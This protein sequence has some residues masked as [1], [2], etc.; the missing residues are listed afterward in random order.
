MITLCWEM[1]WSNC[2]MEKW[3]LESVFLN[4][5][6]LTE[7]RNFLLL[8]SFH[9]KF[10]TKVRVGKIQKLQNFMMEKFMLKSFFL[11]WNP[12]WKI[13]T[14][15]GNFSSK[16]SFEKNFPTKVRVCQLNTSQLNIEFSNLSVFV[17]FWTMMLNS[18]IQDVFF[19]EYTDENK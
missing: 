17:L 1:S 18:W 15:V 3:M 4:W 10:P 9:K 11:T 12:S 6:K 16:V 13:V 8:F 19:M 7:V 5:K 2:M 14:E